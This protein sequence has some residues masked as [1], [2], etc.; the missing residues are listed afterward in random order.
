MSEAA[1]AVSGLSLKSGRRYL[2]QNITWRV[3]KGEN[4]LVF[5]MNGCGK[6]TLLSILAGFKQPTA[7][8]LTLLGETYSHENM[9]ALRKRIGWVSGSFFEQKYTKESALDIVLSGK[10]G[11]LGLERGIRDEDIKRARDLLCQCHLAEKIEQPFHLMSKGERQNVLIARAL[12]AQPDILLLDEPCTGLDILAREQLLFNLKE[13]AQQENLTIIYVTHHTEEIL[14]EVFPKALLLKNGQ[15][16]AQGDTQ[17]L[18]TSENLSAFLEASV[19]VTPR[20]GHGLE[21]N[22]VLD[23]KEGGRLTSHKSIFGRIPILRIDVRQSCRSHVSHTASS[24]IRS[25]VQR[26]NRHLE[27]RRIILS[28][29]HRN[30]SEEVKY[31]NECTDSEFT[32]HMSILKLFSDLPI[33][34]VRA[35]HEPLLLHYKLNNPNFIVCSNKIPTFVF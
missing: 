5:G 2:L 25:D 35:V 14:L 33:N 15:V 23:N 28:P 9:L 30:R 32:Y 16:F 17:T 3:P 31:Y 11:T 6:T 13:M 1:F 22:V 20:A 18:F 19:L 24:G 10:F 12:L 4:W 7:G 29:N 34:E 21:T 8:R 26:R 27:Q